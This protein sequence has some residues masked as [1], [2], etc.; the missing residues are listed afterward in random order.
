MSINC[1][2]NPFKMGIFYKLKVPFNMGT[3]LDSW[4]TRPGIFIMESPPPP[5]SSRL[6]RYLVRGEGDGGMGGGV[7]GRVGGMGAGGWGDGG[8]GGWGGGRYLAGLC[9]QVWRVNVWIS[10]NFQVLADFCP[11][12]LY[13]QVFFT[14]NYFSQH[15]NLFPHHIKSINNSWFKDTYFLRIMFKALADRSVPL[16]RG[17]SGNVEICDVWIAIKWLTFLQWLES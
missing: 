4:H 5:P 13:K 6:R 8:T 2:E 17:F 1:V 11:R 10:Y 14:D 16:W 15:V 12:P 7:P 3:L 9:A